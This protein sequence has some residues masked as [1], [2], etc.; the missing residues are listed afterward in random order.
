MKANRAGFLMLAGMV[1]LLTGKMAVAVHDA[2]ITDDEEKC[3]IGT[4]LAQG[5]FVAEAAKCAIK[6]QQAARKGGNAADCVPPFGGATLQCINLAETK[7]EG[8]EQSKCAKVC[9]ECYSGGDCTADSISRTTNNLS[10]ANTF[11]ALIY[12][13]DSGSGDGLTKVEAKCADTAAKTLSKYVAALGKCG[14]K[15][16]ANEH[17]GKIPVGSCVPPASDA[18]TQT[19]INAATTKATSLIDAKCGDTPDCYLPTLDSGAELTGAVGAVV[20]AAYGATYC[21][22]PSGAFLD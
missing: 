11:G 3:Q 18:K 7:A 9:P 13:D 19:C 6:C 8:L 10:Q 21:G 22:S 15:C 17:K 14:Q 20:Q 1:V 2:D 12:C 16:A 4:S 5:K